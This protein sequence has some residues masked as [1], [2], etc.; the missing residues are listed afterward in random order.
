MSLFT[1][2]KFGTFRIHGHTDEDHVQKGRCETGSYFD[3]VTNDAYLSTKIGIEKRLGDP[4][5][6]ISPWDMNSSVK[7]SSEIKTLFV[8]MNEERADQPT[9]YKMVSCTN[10]DKNVSI[11]YLYPIRGNVTGRMKIGVYRMTILSKRIH[12]FPDGSKPINMVSTYHVDCYDE[13]ENKVGQIDV[14]PNTYHIDPSK[15][16][17][18]Y[19]AFRAKPAIGTTWVGEGGEGEMTVTEA[20]AEAC[21]DGVYAPWSIALPQRIELCMYRMKTE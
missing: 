8:P 3:L 11:G 15:T 6:F 4:W 21:L 1:I 18:S 13:K 12:E 17:V 9:D 2:D 14:E 16:L 19:H 20:D 10:T 5:S 7:Y